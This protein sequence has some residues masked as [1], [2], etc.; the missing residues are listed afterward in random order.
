MRP[1]SSTPD[2][3]QFLSD[4]ELL[5]LL[6]PPRTLNEKTYREHKYVGGVPTPRIRRMQY[7]HEVR[8][9]KAGVEWEIV[10][11]RIAYRKYDGNCGICGQHVP[12]LR[13]SFDHIVPLSKGGPHKLDNLQPAHFSCNSRKGDR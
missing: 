7:A 8:A 9:R 10:D 12:L 11:L 1:S 5:E 3:V 6:G 4:A 2:S 13:A